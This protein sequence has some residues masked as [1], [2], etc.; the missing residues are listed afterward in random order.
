[1]RGRVK[2]TEKLVAELQAEP[3]KIRTFLTDSEVVGF[4]ACV[5]QTGHKTYQL[6]RNI[7]GSV[8]TIG[9]C[10]D[11]KVVEARELARQLCAEIGRGVNPNQKKRAN[12]IKGVTLQMAFDD[13]LVIRANL[14]KN[15]VFNYKTILKKHLVDWRNKPLSEITRD[16]VARRHK[17]L[18]KVSKSSANKSMR[19]L[20]AIF[21]F[22]HGQYEDENGKGLFPDN[23]VSRLTHT[24]AWN[25][26]TRRK[27]RIKNTE[28][29]P[30]FTAALELQEC[31]VDY[32]QMVSDYL[33][34]TLLNG[35]RRR[36]AAGL[37][38]EDVDLSEK[39]FTISNTKSG[40]PLTLPA[41]DFSLDILK[42]RIA[43]THNNFVFPGEGEDIPIDDPRRC[44]AR[45]RQASGVYFTIH[46]LRRTF[47]TIAE[48]LDI[49]A[50]AVKRLVN[51]SVGS[52][53]T[54]GYIVWDEERL[55]K[56]MQ[57]ITDYV[58]KL[59]GVRES[60]HIS[61]L[62]TQSENA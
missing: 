59:A 13:Y 26:E 53:V 41:S 28:L 11:F 44:I 61:Q 45:V 57:E 42:R 55:R 24:K 12:R 4:R 1:M 25:K 10:G 58:L 27:S 34:F 62:P 16:H 40:E 54:A 46:D 14:S 51:H 31:E 19:V 37:L 52:D 36:E 29:R 17:E 39:T 43:H 2:L 18:S 7:I 8:V 21:N 9:P 15:T 22:A 47:I 38:V 48:S 5:T 3:S 49:S 6:K 23:P 32:D 50:Y 60:A 20:R 30:W 35:L 56:P 33:I